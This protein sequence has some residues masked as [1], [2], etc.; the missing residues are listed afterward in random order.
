MNLHAEHILKTHGMFSDPTIDDLARFIGRHLTT[1]KDK[2][3]N[4]RGMG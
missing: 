1:Q 3:W 2:T 4:F